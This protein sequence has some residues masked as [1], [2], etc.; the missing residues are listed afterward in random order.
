MAPRPDTP[1][2]TPARRRPKGDGTVFYD[3]G[4]KRWIGKATVGGKRFKVVETSKAAAAQRLRD[5]AAQD[6]AGGIA[7]P[8][9]TVADVLVDWRTHAAPNRTTQTATLD[10]Y[11]WAIGRL[12][13]VLGR[14]KV[15]DLRPTHVEAAL[16]T[17]ADDGLTRPSLTKIRSVLNMAMKRAMTHRVVTFNPVAGAE[18]PA[19]AQRPGPPLQVLT[20]EQV[21]TFQEALVG[22][23]WEAMYLLMLTGGLRPGEAAAVCADAVH[24]DVPGCPAVVEV[25]RARKLAKGKGGLGDTLKN[26]WSRRAVDLPEW[27]AEALRRHLEATG[28]TG[29]TLLF[30]DGKGGVVTAGVVND[31]LAEVLV[32]AGL[33]VLTAN[34]LRHT[35]ATVLVD[36]GV[37]LHVVAERLG[38]ADTRMVERTYRHRPNVRPGANSMPTPGQRD[39][40]LRIVS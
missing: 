2:T 38:H 32:A 4:R 26:E 3:R 14:R 22:H 28:A 7:D 25:Q 18:L 33:P 8:K 9:A 13:E 11:D 1:K 24:F 35:H 17:L 29:D 23:P 27:T 39:A 40:R 15:A 10:A 31:R 19:D 16:R 6:A 21:V 30:P 36:N 34:M 5:L 20:A 12:V 37:A